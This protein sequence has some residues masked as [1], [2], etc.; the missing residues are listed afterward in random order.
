MASL[1]DLTGQWWDWEVRRWDAAS[2]QLIADNDLT[3]HHSV[4]VT[5]TDVVWVACADTFHHPVFRPPTAT[6][7]DFARQAGNTAHRVF[8]WD[9]E[10]STGAAPMMIV[11]GTAQITEGHFPHNVP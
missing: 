2:L 11:A 8:T 6:E 10:T 9:A 5:F 4:E 3:Y 1:T 7:L